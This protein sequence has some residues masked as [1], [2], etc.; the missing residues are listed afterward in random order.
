MPG[1]ATTLSAFHESLALAR[2]FRI[3]RG[4]KT[5]AEVVTV[6]IGRDGKVGRGE[7][8]PYPRYGESVKSALAAIEAQRGPIEAGASR[9]DILDLMP[10]GA[11]RNALDC[12]LWDLEA[13]LTGRSVFA[14]LGLKEPLAPIPTALTV[15]LDTPAA[16]G[17]AA[18]ALAGA[19]LVKVKVD[20][21]DPAAQLRAVRDAA[22]DPRLVVDPNESWSMKKVEGLQDLMVD[23]RVDLLEQPLPAGE[24][25]AFD[26]FSSSIPIAA[27]ESI[28]TASDLDDLASGYAVVNVKLEKAGGLTG[29][30][31]L[32]ERARERELG[33]MI[34][35]MI[36]SS[37]SIAPAL[38]LAADSAFADLDGPLWLL[39]DRSGGVSCDRGMLH[40]P[41]EGF[42]GAAN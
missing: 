14:T 38:A 25:R 13:R 15:G 3:S 31:Q 11:A 18:R 33:I 9:H 2:P 37:L 6:A 35:C 16:M 5:A 39:E 32:I 21:S 36:S 26:R 17:D 34:G 4:V 8:V 28:H 40:P 10:A 29:A 12:A 23:L 19:P 7:G 24:D 41:R 42:W 27:D 1:N 30:L 22:P 20:A